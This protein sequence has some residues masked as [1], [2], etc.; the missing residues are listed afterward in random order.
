MAHGLL[1]RT[2]GNHCVPVRADW[3][4]PSSASQTACPWWSH[5]ATSS[6]IS[7]MVAESTEASAVN[8]AAI[9]QGISFL[10][11]AAKALLAEECTAEA[12]DVAFGVS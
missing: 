12:A 3:L 10:S 11:E 6:T 8:K 2:G 4:K 5:G 7:Q 1:T 9:E